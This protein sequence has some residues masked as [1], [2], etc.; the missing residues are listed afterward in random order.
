MSLALVLIAAGAPVFLVCSAGTYF[1]RRKFREFSSAI[2]RLEK[3]ALKL[4]DH[5]TAWV[6]FGISGL[7]ATAAGILLAVAG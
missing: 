6:A 3:A 7:C 2:S 1:N 5:L 4:D